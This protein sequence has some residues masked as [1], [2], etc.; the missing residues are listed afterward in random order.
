M[1]HS[2]RPNESF[3]HDISKDKN[4]VSRHCDI[5]IRV[6]LIKQIN[7]IIFSLGM[8]DNQSLIVY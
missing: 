5:K 1:I 4:D 6:K 8:Q 7:Y 3:G 2:N